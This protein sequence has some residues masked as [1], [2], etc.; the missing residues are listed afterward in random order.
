MLLVAGGT[1]WPVGSPGH[2]VVVDTDTIE[3]STEVDASWRAVELGRFPTWP[4]AHAALMTVE[5]LPDVVREKLHWKW[6]RDPRLP[7]VPGR[8]GGRRP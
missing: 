7:A 8:Q 2:L 6:R 1:G 4:S 3:A 5:L